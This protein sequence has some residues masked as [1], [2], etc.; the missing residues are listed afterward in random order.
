MSYYIEKSCGGS[1]VQKVNAGEIWSVDRSGEQREV[2]VIAAHKWYATVLLL[3]DKEPCENGIQITCRDHITCR[4]TKWTDIGKLGFIYNGSFEQLIKKMSSDEFRK[5]TGMMQSVLG[6]GGTE[7]PVAV[8]PNRPKETDNSYYER[9]I[10]AE[11]QLAL[12][13]ELYK[14]L[15]KEVGQKGAS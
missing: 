13:A 7:K 1:S 2:I 11:G 8:K 4:N 3:V 15:L 10:R 9:A 5:V 12:Y 6:I 14:D